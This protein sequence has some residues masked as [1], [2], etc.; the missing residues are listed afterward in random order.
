M[1]YVYFIHSENKTDSGN[2]ALKIGCTANIKNRLRSLQDGNPND[3]VLWKRLAFETAKEAMTIE[4]RVHLWLLPYKIRGEWFKCV[5]IIYDVINHLFNVGYNQ[6]VKDMK[7]VS[8]FIRKLYDNPKLEGIDF[9]AETI[10]YG[11][12]GFHFTA[13]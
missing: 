2:C 8:P 4:K 6:C 11:D 1:V 9:D 3:V 10:I 13:L 12:G 5:P 7:L